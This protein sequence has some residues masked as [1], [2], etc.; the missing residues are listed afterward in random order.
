[1]HDNCVDLDLS[2]HL[3]HFIE[4]EL[5]LYQP[6]VDWNPRAGK[7]GFS[8]EKY[9]AALVGL[10]SMSVQEMA[11]EAGVKYSVLRKW[12]SSDDFKSQISDNIDR[13]VESVILAVWNSYKQSTINGLGSTVVNIGLLSTNVIVQLG[14]DFIDIMTDADYSEISFI[15]LSVLKPIFDAFQDQDLLRLL[16]DRYNLL[17][18]K[19]YLRERRKFDLLSDSE[20]ARRDEPELQLLD[21][22]LSKTV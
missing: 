1:M 5:N 21:D 19:A 9:Y 13:F 14:S 22:F 16:R 8:R 12:R 2:Q 6:P 3:R 10:T 20:Q 7:V 15:Y 17:L 4:R 18:K 11:V